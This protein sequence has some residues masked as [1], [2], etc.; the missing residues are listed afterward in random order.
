MNNLNDMISI[1]MP[2]YNAGK[3][4]DQAIESV[5]KQTY[6]DWELIIVD[7]ASIDNTLEIVRKYVQKDNRIKY[8]LRTTN[9]GAARIPRLDSVQKS[10]GT[11]ILNLDA[12]D[13]I[14]S[15][16]LYK[17]INRARQTQADCVL[18]RM[19]RIDDQKAMFNC[20]PDVDWDMNQCMPGKEACAFTLGYW[21][22]NCAGLMIKDYIW[23]NIPMTDS[24][25]NLMN[26][27]EIDSR[28]LLLKSSKVCFCNAIYYYRINPNSITSNISVKLFHILLTHREL[29]NISIEYYKENSIEA[30][31]VINEYWSLVYCFRIKYL[32]W[33]KKF[34]QIERNQIEEL[35]R[36]SYIY[37]S[38]S[39]MA[40]KEG[41]IKQK[42]L[43]G[44]WIRFCFITLIISIYR[45]KYA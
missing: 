41:S 39:Y 25:K 21:K 16:Y 19:W 23:K 42:I 12:D 29:I 10:N 44:S 3:Y 5:L 31:R 18:S 9:S 34:S 11:W 27:D 30:N 38:N 37:I 28:I 36:N 35:V 7:D 43:Y 15:D 8:Y 26:S 33:R 13:Y 17:M 40:N 6:S 4:I 20:I 14:E 45:K 22:I 24:A 32:S 2:A 1:V